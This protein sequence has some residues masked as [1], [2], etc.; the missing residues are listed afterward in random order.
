MV[1]D[2]G[3][4]CPARSGANGT[5]F[6]KNMEL[7]DSIITTTPQDYENARSAM[8]HRGMR[9]RSIKEPSGTGWRLWRVG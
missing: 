8:R 4:P 6:L 1:L 7:G 2:K 9:Y 3:I 5:F